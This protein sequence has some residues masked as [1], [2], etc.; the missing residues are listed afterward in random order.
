MARGGLFGLVR[1]AVKNSG[2]CRAIGFMNYAEMIAAEGAGAS[3]RDTGNI[4]LDWR[5]L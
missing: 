2:K 5:R 4:H 1:V 3:D